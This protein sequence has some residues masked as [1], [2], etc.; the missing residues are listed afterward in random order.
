MA[1]GDTHAVKLSEE[2]GQ[3][4]RV[5]PSLTRMFTSGMVFWS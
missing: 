3:A 5:R 4:H 2:L 1:H